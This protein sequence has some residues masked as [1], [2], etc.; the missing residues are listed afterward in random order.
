[1]TTSKTFSGLSRVAA[2]LA[3]AIP[4]AALIVAVFVSLAPAFAKG[5]NNGA[6]KAFPKTPGHKSAPTSA[7]GAGAGR[8]P[9][10][11]GNTPGAGAGRPPGYT[12]NIPGAGAGRPPG[13]SG[14][15]PGAGAGKT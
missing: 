4:L 8:P 14:N 9:G 2:V 6:G 5:G 1:M 10:Y 11:S 13:Y 12:G 3:A 7:G 15:T